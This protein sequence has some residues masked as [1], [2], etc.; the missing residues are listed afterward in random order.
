VDRPWTCVVS[1]DTSPAPSGKPY[2]GR[3]SVGTG[4]ST[5]RRRDEHAFARER[6]VVGPVETEAGRDAELREVAPAVEGLG[7]QH[8]VVAG[9]GLV[10]LDHESEGDVD[11]VCG[12]VDEG[13]LELV[14]ILLQLVGVLVS[15]MCARTSRGCEDERLTTASSGRNRA[16]RAGLRRPGFIDTRSAGDR[17]RREFATS[18]AGRRPRAPPAPFKCRGLQPRAARHGTCPGERRRRH[19]AARVE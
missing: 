18:A 8:G 6:Q 5:A 17:D 11:V 1:C 7:V 3:T 16:S 2:C 14:A 4:R 13:W 19:G 15:L 10:V 9:L 12:A